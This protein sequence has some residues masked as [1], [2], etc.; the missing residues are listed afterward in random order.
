MFDTYSII[1]VAAIALSLISLRYRNLLFTL[2]G[3]LGWIALWR[4]HQTNPPT[5]IVAGS[6]VHE[7]LMYGYIVMAI[8]VFVMWVRN[9]ERGYTGYTQTKREQAQLEARYASKQ[10]RRGI[11]EMSATEYRAYLRNRLRKRRR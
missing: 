6:F 7:V 2:G 11:M 3:V 1:L 9:R 4:F 5:S 8:A 10:P